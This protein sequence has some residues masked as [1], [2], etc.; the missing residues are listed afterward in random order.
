V[1]DPVDENPAIV[2]AIVAAGG[3]VQFVTE[4]LPSLEDVYLRLVRE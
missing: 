1:G 2:D 3:R 4:V